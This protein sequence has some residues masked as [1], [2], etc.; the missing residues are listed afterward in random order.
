MGIP[1]YFKTLVTQYQDDI[2]VKKPLHDIQ[3][4]FFD[5]NCL[6]H[7]CCKS[8]SDTGISDEAQM[9]DTILHYI[10]TLIAYTDAKTLVYIAIDGVCPKAK[11]KQ[12]RERRHKSAYEAK[13]WDTNAISPGTEFM[14]RLN[15]RIREWMD[16]YEGKP[17]IILSDSS[18]PGEGE[19]K[20]LEYLRQ[21]P[22]QGKTVIYGLDADLVMLGLVSG[23]NNIYLLRERTAYNIEDTESPYIYLSIPELRLHILKDIGIISRI[24]KDVVIHDYIF[25]CFLLGNDFINHC[26]SL[27]LRYG[28]LETLLATYK[29]LQQRYMGHYRLIDTRLPTCIQLPFFKEFLAE[30]AKTEDRRLTQIRESRRKQRGRV[31]RE[32]GELYRTF[33]KET[34]AIVKQST[35]DL[36]QKSSQDPEK[37]R[38]MCE[39]LPLLCEVKPV[40]TKSPD[41][42]QD[43]IDSIVWTAIYYFRGC[44]SWTWHTEF[45]EVPL[46]KHLYEYIRDIPCLHALDKSKP[47]TEV[48]QL[49]YI[50]PPS[51]HS[52]HRYEI[53]GKAIKDLVYDLRDK[54][55]L[56]EC[57]IEIIV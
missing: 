20:I 19:H 12:Q 9:I 16:I 56:W 46:I 55:Y 24:D 15:L 29:L 3:S 17:Q 42:S 36:F 41:V 34:G 7:P 1:V 23:I 32:Y 8:V 33:P 43:Y 57:E 26:P 25:M 10:E 2:L 38:E 21:N 40:Y 51:S 28:G 5:L 30:L 35:M 52:L 31:I 4:L 44:E 39:H 13:T 14:R 22:V 49:T 47:L 53:Q 45:S 6:I 27:S 18:E 50:F 48:E 37:A 11:M 54:R